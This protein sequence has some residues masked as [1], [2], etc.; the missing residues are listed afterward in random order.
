MEKNLL[1]IL[2]II[3]LLLQLSYRLWDTFEKIKSRK[4]KIKYKNHNLKKSH[5]SYFS[6]KM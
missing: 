1:E 3:A 5:T 6:D 4:K 2:A